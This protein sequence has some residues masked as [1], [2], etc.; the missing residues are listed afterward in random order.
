MAYQNPHPPCNNSSAAAGIKPYRCAINMYLICMCGLHRVGLIGADRPL[1]SRENRRPEV[2]IL[3]SYLCLGYR[4]GAIQ[5]W[6]H[7]G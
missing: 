1:R 4:L 5:L 2:R 6:I 7:T 3:P